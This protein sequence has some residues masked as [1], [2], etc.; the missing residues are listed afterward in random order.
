MKSSK[1]APSSATAT[2]AGALTS[3]SASAIDR[4]QFNAFI[5]LFLL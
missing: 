1:S 5:S 2:V 4:N 3:S